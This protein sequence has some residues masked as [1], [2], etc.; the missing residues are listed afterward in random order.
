M[1]ED[2]KTSRE[3]LAEIEVEEANGEAGNGG[4]RGNWDGGEKAHNTDS[5][6]RCF[7]TQKRLQPFYREHL[8]D[9]R[10]ISGAM[11][12]QGGQL[13]PQLFE[14]KINIGYFCG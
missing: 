9:V 10:T 8:L 7:V 3:I 4:M 5:N 13:T 12:G 6:P 11:L 1:K 2:L 14:K